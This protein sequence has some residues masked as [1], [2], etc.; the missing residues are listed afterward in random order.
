M[1]LFIDIESINEM[2]FLL[3]NFLSNF[4]S[5][6]LH[7]FNEKTVLFDAKKILMRLNISKI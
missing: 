6:S 1:G 2:N 3:N 4:C 7:I 5:E